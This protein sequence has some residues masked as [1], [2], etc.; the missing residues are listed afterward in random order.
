ML[1]NPGAR[2]RW[3]NRPLVTVSAENRLEKG[4]RVE[5]KVLFCYAMYTYFRFRYNCKLLRCTYHFVHMCMHDRVWR[6][7]H[8][9][10]C[11]WD[12]N[13]HFSPTHGTCS[14]VVGKCK[15]VWFVWWWLI[16]AP[17]WVW[18]HVRREVSPLYV[19]LDTMSMMHWR[20]HHD[21]PIS[22][23]CLGSGVRFWSSRRT[24]S[25][26]APILR[27]SLMDKYA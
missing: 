1:T 16:V 24:P 4:E 3:N 18:V 19:L 23:V 21:N 25:E 14:A 12:A 10:P 17:M 5:S 13:E 26:L 7:T 2:A 20:H 11:G 6:P 27:R 9:V 8:W 15:C 22:W